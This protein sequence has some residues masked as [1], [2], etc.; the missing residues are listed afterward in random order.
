M[1][2]GNAVLEELI[3]RDAGRIDADSILQALP[4]HEAVAQTVEPCLQ[5][6]GGTELV[7]HVQDLIAS[8]ANWMPRY[9][10][11]PRALIHNDC[12]PRNMA[13]RREGG[14]LRTCWYDWELCAWAPP[15]RDLA[16]LLCFTLNENDARERSVRY[17]EL[18][19][20]QLSAMV[21]H[22]I[23]SRSWIEGFRLALAELMVRRLALYALLHCSVRQSFLPR[24]VS[25]WKVL[26]LKQPVLIGVKG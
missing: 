18:H 11:Q 23:D 24:V 25:T 17:I 8:M 20:Q 4:L 16:E 6:W 9:A 21:G 3:I 26:S 13:F 10:G 22:E 5:A 19:R 7:S 1:T 2:Y 15:Q 14:N 12:N